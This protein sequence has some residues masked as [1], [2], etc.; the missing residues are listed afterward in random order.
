MFDDITEFTVLCIYRIIQGVYCFI[1]SYTLCDYNV[2]LCEEEREWYSR[3]FRSKGPL[4]IE[5]SFIHILMK[6]FALSNEHVKNF[7]HTKSENIM[8]INN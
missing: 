2:R 6:A 8:L 7:P 5:R 3:H 1:N 4:F